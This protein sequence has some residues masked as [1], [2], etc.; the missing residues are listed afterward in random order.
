MREDLSQLPEAQQSQLASIYAKPASTLPAV[1]FSN[2]NRIMSA[3]FFLPKVPLLSHVRRTNPHDK[4][5]F[6]EVI[7][8]QKNFFEK[9][10]N[11]CG[12]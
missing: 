3:V 8:M 6:P 12:H 4:L 2:S 9:V 1:R 7:N 11:I 5:R 10:P